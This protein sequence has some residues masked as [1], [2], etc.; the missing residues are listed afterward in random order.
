MA[1]VLAGKLGV[2][3]TFLTFYGGLALW[4]VLRPRALGEWLV[5][6]ALAPIVFVVSVLAEYV[7][8]RLIGRLWPRWDKGPTSWRR[9]LAVLLVVFILAGGGFLFLVSRISRGG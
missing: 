1:G 9:T 6:C 8:P 4:F 3:A 2:A 7:C 5:F